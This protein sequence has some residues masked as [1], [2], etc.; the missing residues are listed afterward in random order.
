[1]PV[2][3]AKSILSRVRDW[4]SRGQSDL[5]RLQHDVALRSVW[6]QSIGAAK[7]PLNKFGAKYFS[8]ADEDGITLEIVRRLGL[9][10]GTFAELG[11]GDG[12][13]NNTLI[14]LANN[15]RGFWIGGQKLSF[16]ATVNP[17]R[18]SFFQSW[19]SQENIVPLIKTG[20]GRLAADDVDVLSLDLDGNDYYFIRK[21]L[22]SGILPKLFIVEYNGKFPP[23][24]KWTIAYDPDHHWDG[25]D[26]HGASI[27]LLAE[28]FSQHSYTL[29]CCNAATGVNAFFVRNQFLSSFADVPTAIEDIFVGGRYQL[30]HRWGNPPSPKTIERMLKSASAV[31]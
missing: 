4:F 3:I 12:L 27:A 22:Q 14:L 7:N 1:M 26:Y 2:E 10:S 9:D 28:L 23:P 11:V 19:V 17:D 15:W 16:D 29:V 18:F 5:L 25:T 24:I 30:F 6:M 21:V 31:V 8:Q 20:L 13:E